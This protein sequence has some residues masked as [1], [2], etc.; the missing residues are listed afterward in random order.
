[1]TYDKK[2]WRRTFVNLG[3]VYTVCLRKGRDVI[4]VD[5]QALYCSAMC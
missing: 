4:R 2:T 5:S 1:M 3:C